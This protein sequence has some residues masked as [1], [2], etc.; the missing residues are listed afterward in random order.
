LRISS[1][2]LTCSTSFASSA[3]RYFSLDIYYRADY[4]DTLRTFNDLNKT[5]TFELTQARALVEG[6][7]AALAA[8]NISED[9]LNALNQTLM[10]MEHGVNAEQADEQFHYIISKATRNNALVY[11][12]EKFWHLRDNQRN[13]KEAYAS[14]CNA[15]TTERINEHR[16]I[17]NA[18]AERDSQKARLAMHQHFARLINALFDASEA[19]ALEEI[20]RRS[21][22]TRGL[23][24]I[25]SVVTTE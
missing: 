21:N 14:V 5:V 9:E 1:S 6:E 15:C 23:Y 18:L 7:A 12:V 11:S 24:S 13:I 16:E 22:E 4:L 19:K 8:A 10:D 25:H 2:R 3:I 20:K 17:Y